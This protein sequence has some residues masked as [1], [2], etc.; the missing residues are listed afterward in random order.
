M[1]LDDSQESASMIF[2]AKKL[3]RQKL[4]VKKWLLWEEYWIMKVLLCSMWAGT[5]NCESSWP[6][7]IPIIQLM[8]WIRD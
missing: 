7:L 1:I 6:G 8:D 4:K 3:V 2:A 5:I